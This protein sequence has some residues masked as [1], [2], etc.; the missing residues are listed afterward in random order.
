MQTILLQ[1]GGST[2]AISQILLFGGMLAVFYFFMFRPQQKKQKE[3]KNFLANLKRGDSVI[4]IG[5]LH[6]K[7]YA[8]NENTVTLDIDGKG[9]RLVFEKSAI[10]RSFEPLQAQA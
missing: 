6:G 4:T 2:Q 5:G 8:I 9:N 3:Q 10:S 7:I 1:A